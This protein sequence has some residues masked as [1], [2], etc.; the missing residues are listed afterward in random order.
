MPIGILDEQQRDLEATE[1]MV[2]Q[3]LSATADLSAA[4]KPARSARMPAP[5]R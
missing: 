2:Q 4:S 5:A 3:W 1:Q